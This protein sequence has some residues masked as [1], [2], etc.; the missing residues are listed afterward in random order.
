MAAYEVF[1][2]VS[3]DVSCRGVSPLLICQ[4]L[5][6]LRGLERRWQDA[7]AREDISIERLDRPALVLGGL[8]CETSFRPVPVLSEWEQAFFLFAASP[9]AGVLLTSSLSSNRDL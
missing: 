7:L 1:M 5:L 9:T 3:A 8:A 6:W 4:H 2:A